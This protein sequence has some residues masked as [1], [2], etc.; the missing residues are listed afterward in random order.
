M[1]LFKKKEEK[2]QGKDLPLFDVP[3][4]K[5]VK[6]CWD[7]F[8][9]EEVNLRNLI[10]SKAGAN[11]ICDELN[12][13]FGIA[14]ENV[15]AE[16]GFNGEKHD[17]ILNLEGDWSRLF[18]LAYFKRMAPAEVYDNWNIIVGRRS[19]G[20][21]INRFE[22]RLGNNSV[23]AEDIDIWSNWQNGYVDLEIY[24]KNMLPLI[25]ND[26]SQAFQLMFILLDQAVGELAEM[27]YI[28][29]ID[30]LDNPK[31]E[32]PLKLDGLLDDFITN[33]FLSKEELMDAERYIDL[34][35]VYQLQ[36]DE[37]ATDGLR[38]D[39]F[40][41]SSCLIPVI[42]DFR[43]NKTY[44][45]DSFEK[46]GI[47]AGYIFY[48]LDWASGNDRSAKIL[49]FRDSVIDEIEKTCGK[50]CFSFLGGATGVNYG[51][52]DFVAYDLKAVTDAITD[53]F[54]KSEV[55]FVKYHSFRKNNQS[56]TLYQK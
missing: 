33:L 51:Y 40:G 37:N 24:C 9:T 13:I 25:K 36:P 47:S 5:R 30:F 38:R 7:Y 45:V 42:N 54:S 16:V 6:D 50:E 39:V 22:L 55:S 48:P 18:S 29:S 1:G 23:S 44:I 52:L 20:Q 43:N 41:G 32:T 11:A 27:K 2:N 17:L 53:I 26:R 31:N 35:S 46:D 8:L 12:K 3:F 15:Y 21:A 14:F 56:V 34:Y 4:R 28:A 49:D 10:D 19:N